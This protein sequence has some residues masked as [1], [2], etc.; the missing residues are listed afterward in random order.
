M[1]AR[2]RR[3]LTQFF[4]TPLALWLSFPVGAAVALAFAP[5]NLWPLAIA[6]MTYLFAAWD[7]AAPRRAAKIGFL[8]TAGTFLAGTYWLYHSIHIIGKAPLLLTVFII[9]ALVAIMAAYTAALGWV[10]ARLAGFV[11]AWRWLLLLP[12]MWTLVEW[13]RGWF[14][15]GFPWLALGY[16][17]TDTWLAA[18]A[19]IGGVYFVSLLV[20][21]CAGALLTVLRGTRREQVMALGVVVAMWLGAY[22]LWQR[23]WTQPSGKPLSVALVQGA[24]E[25]EMKWTPEQREKTLQLYPRLTEPYLGRDLI[26]WPEAALPLPAH[27]LSGYLSTQWGAAQ[28]RGSTLMLGV[29]R[30]EPERRT[31]TNSI[32]T[33]NDTLQWYDKRRLVPF[34]EFFP[35]PKFVRDWLK[36]M[37]LPF[38]GFRRG[39]DDQPPASVQSQKIAATICYEDAFGADQ[40]RVLREATVLVN[41]TNDAWF[42][43]TSARYQHLQISRMRALEAG[44]PLLRAAQ[45]GI[46]AIIDPQGRIAQSLPSFEPGVLAGDVQPRT[47]L[48]PYAQVGNWPLVLAC[49]AIAVVA[50]VRRERSAVAAVPDFG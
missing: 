3:I 6:C 46:S 37:D 12:A 27:Q 22:L 4:A 19:P 41:V 5:Y 23:D 48:T 7:N 15:S 50:L 33:L 11:G 31:Y 49:L 30:Y 44:R 24:V 25:Q 18:F 32:L 1:H 28:A 39:V 26:V 16:S 21:T 38:S 40:L 47:G 17:Q 29:I 13:F 43:D 34:S 45:D 20:A 14:L 42:G 2:V 36:G 8:F 9:L 10:Q 35:V